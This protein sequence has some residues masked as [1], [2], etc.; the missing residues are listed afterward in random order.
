MADRRDELIAFWIKQGHSLEEFHACETMFV[1]VR[2]GRPDLIDGD[3]ADP[4]DAFAIG[5]VGGMLF[6]RARAK[7]QACL[8]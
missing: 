8:N 6:E 1:A 2:K 3:D 7:A 5:F 4:Y